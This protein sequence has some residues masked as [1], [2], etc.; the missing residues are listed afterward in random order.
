M[1]RKFL[2]VIGML[3]FLLFPLF[4][5]GKK[6]I[7]KIGPFFA[8][9]KYKELSEASLVAIGSPGIDMAIRCAN[10]FEIWGSYKFSKTTTEHGHGSQDIFRLDAF[11]AGLAYKPVRTGCF[12]PFMGIGLDYYHFADDCGERDNFTYF[13]FPV[14]SAI[15]CFVQGGVYIHFGRWCI[16]QFFFKYNLVLILR[17]APPTGERI[18]TGPISAA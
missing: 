14:R 1:K 6:E 5:E 4:S 10:H 17:S 11:A 15:G 18:I 9:G 13:I 8:F 3:S 16:A 2:V 12:E 7:L